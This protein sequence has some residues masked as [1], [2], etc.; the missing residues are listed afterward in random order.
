MLKIFLVEDE[1]VVREGIKNNIDWSSHGYDFVGEASDGELAL[2]MIEKLK[3]DIVITD[4]KMP[5]MDGLELSRMIKQKF[6]WMEIVILSGYAEFDYAKEAISIG[7]AHYLTKPINGNDLLKQIDSLAEKIEEKKREREL[8]E[9]Y[10]AEMAEN[11]D[12]DKRKLF[13]HMVTGDMNITEMLELARN[14]SL[15]ISAALYCVML[16]QVVSGHH[17]QTE[18]SGSVVSLYEKTEEMAEN[19]GAIVFDRNIEGKAVIFRADNSEDMEA[20]ISKVVDSMEELFSKYDHISYYG[21]I[22]KPAERLSG[23]PKS[24]AQA[25]KAYAHRFF[26]DKNNIRRYVSVDRSEEGIT[27]NFSISSIDPKKL[28]RNRIIEFLRKGQKDE[29]EY[30]TDEFLGNLG[31][32]AV[33]S[34]MFRHYLATEVYF[35]VASFVEELGGERAVIEIFDADKEPL[36][37]YFIR[38][39]QEAMDLREIN[40]S[41]RYGGVI[42]EVKA[43]IDENYGDEGLSLNKLAGHVNF[44][45]N[46]LSM[47]FS[48]QTGMTFIKYLTDY[49]MNKAKELL[50]CTS[51]KGADISY[52][53]GYKDPHYFS[54]LFKRTQ[55]MTPTQYRE[56]FK[57]ED[58]IE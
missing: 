15:D 50:R 35:A 51:K 3:P 6:P 32:S 27:E 33:N 39:M 56:G 54:Y 58:S 24:F 43:Y 34:A 25:S 46:H 28:S 4:I 42:D 8:K 20:K 38:I 30:F 26:T 48:A 41:N 21:G 49:R 16:F 19:E 18:Y 23:L 1:F 36:R 12:G 29:A 57:K 5:F 47:V 31:E 40:A 45:P 2:P 22:G 7:V 14:L 44:S 13:S 11:S 52:E 17:L 10:M 37:S 53:V 55:G 9:K